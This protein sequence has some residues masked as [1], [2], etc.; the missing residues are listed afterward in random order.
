M[1]RIARS[2]AERETA[3]RPQFA[4]RALSR[5]MVAAGGTC[6]FYAGRSVNDRCATIHGADQGAGVVEIALTIGTI[7]NRYKWDVVLV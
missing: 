1:R 3:E 2:P 5:A 4:T 7:M 6:N